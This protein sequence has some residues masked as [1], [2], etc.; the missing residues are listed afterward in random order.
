[1]H[2]SVPSLIT[3]L[4]IFLLVYQFLARDLVVCLGKL[5]DA[6]YDQTSVWHPFVVGVAATV[7]TTMIF[8]VAGVIFLDWFNKCRLTG[9]YEAFELGK[10]GETWM[11]WGIVTI[12]Y[13][14]FSS[15]THHT[16]VKLTLEFNNGDDKVLLQGDGIIIDN[17]YLAGHYAE[18]GRPE[19]RRSGSFTYEISGQGNEWKGS[20]VSISPDLSKP[21]KGEAKWVSK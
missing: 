18:V 21:T 7:I 19:R 6:W 11:P 14:P 9:K 20:F 17:R 16:P 13:H 5:L 4:V 3:V 10:D 2:F 1:M 12:A 8:A 15:T